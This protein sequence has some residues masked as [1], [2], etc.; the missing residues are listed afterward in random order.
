M[1][2]K[3]LKNNKCPKCNADLTQNMRF[4][5][6]ILNCGFMCSVKRFNAIINNMYTSR[7]III[8]DYDKNLSELNNL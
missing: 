2:W 5:K 8:N 4:V 1:N 3:N 7:K 6:C